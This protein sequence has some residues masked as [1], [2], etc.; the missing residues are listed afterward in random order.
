MKNNLLPFLTWNCRRHLWV[1]KAMVFLGYG[2]NSSLPALG[3]WALWIITNLKTRQTRVSCY[4]PWYISQLWCHVVKYWIRSEVHSYWK[5]VPAK[6][7]ISNMLCWK[8]WKWHDITLWE[9]EHHT[10]I[11]E[12]WDKAS[13]PAF[14]CCALWVTPSTPLRLR[15]GMSRAD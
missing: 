15:R 1:V 7:L 13:A 9:K 8:A 5:I 3:R 12:I 10:G 6:L 11:W 14:P 2:F 4:N